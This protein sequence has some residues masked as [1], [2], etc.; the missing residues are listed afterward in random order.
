MNLI[1]H[2]RPDIDKVQ[3]YFKDP[4]ESNYQLLTNGREKGEFVI[5]KNQKAFINYS[6]TIYDVYEN[7]E[8]YDP[9]KKWRDVNSV[10]RHDRRH[11]I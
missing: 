10:W 1:K 2:Q 5:L 8:D 11:G 7:L 9:T 6:E 4:L 3:L